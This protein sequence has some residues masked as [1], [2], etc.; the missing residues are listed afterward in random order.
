MS[1]D[2]RAIAISAT[3]TAE[4]IEAALA[5]WAGELALPYEIRF[6]AY[7]QLFQELLAPASL[8]ACNRGFNVALVRLDDWLAAGVDESARRF[9]DAVKSST[10][11]APLILAL[12]P[13]APGHAA[14]CEPAASLI[15][16]ALAD[17]PAV[18]FAH[19][20]PVANP[21][22]PYAGELGHLPYTPLFF[23]SLATAIARKIH[24]LSH[25]PYKVIAVH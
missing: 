19:P 2:D 8:F 16:N 5:F 11:V 10:A 4:A 22:D 25:P 7:N 3:F 13:P 6:A 24:A 20:E 12:C 18:Y 14:A 1:S 15:C 9:I 23:V 17:L 21:H